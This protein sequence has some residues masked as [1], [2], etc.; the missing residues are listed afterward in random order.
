MVSENKLRSESTYNRIRRAIVRI[1]KA[2]PK[3][4]TSD[5]KMSVAAVAEE[6]EVSRALIYNEYPELLERIRAISNKSVSTQRDKKHSDLM[7]ERAKNKELRQRIAELKEQQKV[8]VSKVATLE[9]E[10]R[11]L[12]AVSNSD[13]VMMLKKNPQKL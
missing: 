2:R 1:E 8:L 7:A 11:H 12:L 5:R 9:L 4:V 13:N 3:N 6:A 10:N